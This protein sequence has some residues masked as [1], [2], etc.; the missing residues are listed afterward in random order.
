MVSLRQKI[1][2]TYAQWTAFSGT[3][4]GCPLKSRHDIYPLIQLPNYNAILEGNDTVTK[5]EFDD[6]HRSNSILIKTKQPLLS[7]GWTTKL[8]NL[9]LKTMVYIGQFGRPGLVQYIHPPIDN[10]LWDGIAAKYGTESVIIE[11]THLKTK[12]K[13]VSTYDEYRK[14]IDGIELIAERLVCLPIEVEQLWSGTNFKK[15]KQRQ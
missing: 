2:E 12:I 1:S 10:G 7:I 11:K 15:K 4:S 9:Y 14:I 13:E 3:R 5:V 8:I 6:W